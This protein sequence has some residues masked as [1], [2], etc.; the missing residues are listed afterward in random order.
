MYK[1]DSTYF[2][3]PTI[4][5]NN[6]YIGANTGRLTEL[7]PETSKEKTFVTLTERITNQPAYNPHTK[8]FFVP[9]EANELYCLERTDWTDTKNDPV[10]DGVK[11]STTAE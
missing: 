4:I 9:T 10:K 3:S 8:H 2:G 11:L 5:E 7:D 1:H 6:A